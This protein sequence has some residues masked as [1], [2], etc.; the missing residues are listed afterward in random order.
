MSNKIRIIIVMILCSFSYMTLAAVPGRVEVPATVN[1]GVIGNQLQYKPK[2]PSIS[3]GGPPIQQE[4]P[5]APGTFG[6]EAERIKFKLTSVIIEG[7]TVFTTAQLRTLYQDKLNKTITVAELQDIVKSI[8]NYYRNSGY[9]LSRAVI[10]PQHVKEGVVRI[11]IVEGYIGN[12]NVIGHPKGAKDLVAAYGDRIKQSKP[13][14]VKVMERYLFIANDIPGVDTKAVLEPSKLQVGA[15]DL[16]LDTKTDWFNGFLSY[17]NYGTRYIGPQE[18]TAGATANSVFRSGDATRFTYVGTSKG[19]ELQYKDLFY[20]NP[21]GSKG[22]RLSLDANQAL[23]NPLFTLQPLQ[24][25]GIATD[26]NGALRYPIVRSREKN[27]SFE[28]GFNY[29]DSYTTQLDVPLYTDHIRSVRVGGATD[30]A[31]RFMGS[32]QLGAM[33][34]EGIP[35][36]GATTDAQSFFTSRYGATSK[37]TKIGAQASRLQK[38]FGKFSLYGLAKGQYS[39]NPLLAS[40]QFAYGGSQLGR[41]YD[42]AEIIADRGVGGTLELRADTTPGLFNLQVVELYVFYDAGKVWNIRNVQSIPASQSATS[43]GFGARFYFMKYLTGN[44]MWTQPL[45]RKVQSLQQIGNGSLP[46][47]FFS[48]TASV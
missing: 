16:N 14:Q 19:D 13:L 28:T 5:P 42:P 34:T 6:A 48:I 40:E 38:L 4:K 35:C 33:L 21:I 22:W 15:A 36:F 41:G 7:N 9:I 8:T 18:V 26:Y 29:L 3:P 47:I 32:N 11:K 10:P 17:D 1:P 45:S 44:L 43:T 20:D 2:L 12:V 25:A 23:T 39:F 37:Y 24:V 46:R 30:F 27:I 31:D